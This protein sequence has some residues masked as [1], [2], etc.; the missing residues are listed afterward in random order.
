MRRLHDTRGLTPC[1]NFREPCVASVAALESRTLEQEELMDR[2]SLGTIDDRPR[3][4]RSIGALVALGAWMWLVASTAPA[5][6]QSKTCTVEIDVDNA[7]S[8]NALQ[9]AVDYGLATG[10]FQVDSCAG[11]AGFLAVGDDDGADLSV[12]WANSGATFDGPGTFVSCSFVATNGV[13]ATAGQFT[14]SVVDASVGNPPAN[15]ATDPTVSVAV[16]GCVDTAPVCGND[17]VES[18]EECDDANSTNDDGCDDDTASGGNCTISGCGNGV[19]NAG[20]FCDDGNNVNGDGCDAGCF[21]ELAVDKD[22][23]GCIN[24]VNKAA[25]KAAAAYA[26]IWSKCVK[27]V[28][29]GKQGFVDLCYDEDKNLAKTADKATGGADKKCVGVTPS[30]AAGLDATDAL[31]VQAV[32]RQLIENVL[33]SSLTAAVVLKA[34]KAGAKCQQKVLGATNKHAATIWKDVVGCK[35]LGLKN[36]SIVS[37]AGVGACLG[38]DAKGGIAKSLSKLSATIGKSCPGA[39]LDDA[40]D[41]GACAAETDA[42]GLAGCLAD[43]A[44]CAVCRELNAIDDTAVDCATCP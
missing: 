35:K 25:S 13:D 16:S 6:A 39:S 2:T 5:F 29:G 40:F 44:E 4:N 42:S 12:A 33:G 37:P 18:G 10:A 32:E 34:D 17:V 11:P 19:D 30:F 26:K 20:E 22:G 3:S 43:L 15:P 24:A 38:A 23:Q 41:G 27:A 21:V 1:P 31:T 14:P 28:S 36:E 9:V 8:V 7:S